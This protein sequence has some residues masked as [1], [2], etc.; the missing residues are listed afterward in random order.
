[1]SDNIIGGIDS[2]S[3]NKSLKEM[4]EAMETA[5]AAEKKPANIPPEEEASASAEDQSTL[6][7][8]AKNLKPESPDEEGENPYD[9]ML[10]NWKKTMDKQFKKVQEPDPIKPQPA[11]S[12]CQG[13]RCCVGGG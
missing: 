6:G 12:L 5:K 1:M 9:N 3:Q 13:N 7:K 4:L 11:Q 10:K 2:V 8:E